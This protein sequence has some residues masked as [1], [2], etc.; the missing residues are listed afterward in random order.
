MKAWNALMISVAA[1]SVAAAL[2]AVI[3]HE[4]PDRQA[5]ACAEREATLKAAV[6][7]DRRGCLWTLSDVI[8]VREALTYY[9][10]NCKHDAAH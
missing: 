9:D 6:V 4:V 1:V 5:A 10:R 7:C 2:A 8:K 3:W